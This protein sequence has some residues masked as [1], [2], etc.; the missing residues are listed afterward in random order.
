MFTVKFHGLDEFVTEI[1][2]RLGWWYEE[3]EENDCL[4]VAIPKRDFE[5]FRI[6]FSDWEIKE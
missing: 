2:Y 1:C 5:I 6:I 4:L 3:H